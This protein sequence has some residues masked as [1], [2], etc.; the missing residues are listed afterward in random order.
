[1][2]VA[3]AA[4]PT[5]VASAKATSAPSQA[6]IT[7]S[8][9]PDAKLY[10]DGDPVTLSPG[11]RS[12]RTPQL[13]PG[14]EYFYTFKAEA[15]RD[16]ETVSETRRVSFRGG[17]VTRVDFGSLSAPASS[18]ARITVR[19]PEDARLYVDNVL[20]TLTS[21]TRSFDTPELEAG[22][23]YYYTLK[24]EVV[25]DGRTHADSRRVVVQAGKQATVNFGD[26]VSVQ[27]AQ[28]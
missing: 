20:C 14:R 28:R 18:P 21:A 25:R 27:A 8:L 22:K 3:P 24:A 9:S 6:T 2:S 16:G 23:S 10:V 17:D 7:V 15:V 26:L 1:Y 5:I 12:L 11:S 4:S 19:L 13:E